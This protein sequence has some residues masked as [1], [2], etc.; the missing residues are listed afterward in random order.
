[1]ILARVDGVIVSTVCHPSMV[2]CRSVI[3]QPL[4]EQ[5]REEGAPILALDPLSAGM[6]ERVLILADGGK[7]REFVKD[8]KSPLWNII[9]ALIDEPVKE[10]A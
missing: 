3:C 6:H 4:D 9:L 2:G 8:P 7:T 10:N 1:M 5:G